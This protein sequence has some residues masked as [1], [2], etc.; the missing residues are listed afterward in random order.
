MDYTTVRQEEYNNECQKEC[1]EQ[2]KTEIYQECC[3]TNGQVYKFVPE[4]YTRYKEEFAKAVKNIEPKGDEL[5][6]VGDKLARA[7][8]ETITA[9]GG[10]GGH[11]KRFVYLKEHLEDH[12]VGQVAASGSATTS[13]GRNAGVSRRSTGG[14]TRRSGTSPRSTAGACLTRRVLGYCLKEPGH[15]GAARRQ[16]GRPGRD[17][18][19]QGSKPAQA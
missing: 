6:E 12:L 10:S 3:K 11:A 13:R 2:C 8:E 4:C 15:G 18:Q 17:P 5:A 1:E 19:H 16:R 14:T 7:E 9:G